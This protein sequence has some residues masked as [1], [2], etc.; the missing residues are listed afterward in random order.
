MQMIRY[1]YPAE[2]SQGKRIKT[3]DSDSSKGWK[4]DG[5]LRDP[6]KDVYIPKLINTNMLL[7]S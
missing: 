1:V 6:T 7:S 2:S 3:V 4:S 5:Y